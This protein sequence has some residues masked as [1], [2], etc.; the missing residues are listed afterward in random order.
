MGFRYHKRI[1]LGD[2]V[3]INV[4]KSGVST[5]VRTKYG[6]IGSKGFSIRTGI[7][8]LTW[9]SGFGGKNTFPIMLVI[10][11]VMGGLVVAYNLIRFA[12]YLIGLTWDFIFTENGFSFRNFCIVAMGVGA[13]STAI[14]FYA[15]RAE[16]EEP[17]PPTPT[18]IIPIQLPDT[19]TVEEPKEVKPKKKKNRKPIES[20]TDTKTTPI[21]SEPEADRI[22]TEPEQPMTTEP[23]PVMEQVVSGNEETEPAGE[24]NSSN[25]PEGERVEPGKRK[26]KWYQ[27]KK[28]RAE[29][30]QEQ[31]EMQPDQ[32]GS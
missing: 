16:A 14:Y 13:L 7:P 15:N 25:E 20:P 29:K 32:S 4:S 21:I 24:N 1:N 8:G 5:S 2:G 30:K 22:E 26:A 31:V 6:S 27:F 23:T 9:R 18:E 19:S 10:L 12:I 28:R 11:L 17:P 3:G